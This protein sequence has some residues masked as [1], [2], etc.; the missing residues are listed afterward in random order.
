MSHINEARGLSHTGKPATIIVNSTGLGALKLGDVQDT[1][2]RPARGQVVLVR[3][4][5]PMFVTSGN[6]D[7][8]NADLCYAMTRAAGGGSIL[9][10]TYDIGNWESQPDLNIANRI[11]HRIVRKYPEIACGKGVGGLS[12]IRHA[13]G[14]R[15]YREGGARIEEEKLD[16]DTWIIHNYGHAG[17]GY[18]GSY[19]CA[20]DVVKLVQKVQRIKHGDK[21]KL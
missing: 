21:A 20:E 10:G 9:G 7:D 6:D 16:S 15:P 18:Q 17:W 3:N 5:V 13:V 11:M 8:E 1:R 12:V 2:M 4:E 14:L 19:G